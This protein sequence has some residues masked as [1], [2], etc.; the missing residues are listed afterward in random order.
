MCIRDRVEDYEIARYPGMIHKDGIK[1][2]I[3]T[4]M[5]SPKPVT[6]ICIGPLTNIAAALEIEPRIAKKA[7]FVGM[8]GCLRKS[9]P[10]FGGGILAEYNVKSDPKASQ[11]VF[12][13]SWDMT[14]TPIDT[15]GFV[16]LKGKKY[17]MIH[18]CSDP[19]IQDLMEN[20]KTW[21]KSQSENW[22][23]TFETRSSI[24]F[25][26]VAVYLSFSNDLLVMEDLGV[27]V[28]DDGY[29]T[30][31]ENAKTIHCAVEWKDLSAF[32]DFLI[33]RLT[34]KHV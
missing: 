33:E 22:R 14:I 17:Q 13:A 28:T 21:L 3:N 25:D 11:K 16:R 1:R 27:R 23:E 26:T 7:R 15:C 31:D 5:D 8:H 6:L 34:G 19:L 20:Y 4:I 9:P 18:K 30:I 32:E 12:S 24:L 29:T 2:L 10:E